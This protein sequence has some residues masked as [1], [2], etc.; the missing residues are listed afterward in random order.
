MPCEKLVEVMELS[1]PPRVCEWCEVVVTDMRFKRLRKVECRG[2]R[3]PGELGGGRGGASRAMG[4]SVIV[5]VTSRLGP[6]GWSTTSKYAGASPR[7]SGDEVFSCAS[8]FAA[9]PELRL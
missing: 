5:I 7:G 1:E 9:V 2:G 6:S 3:C 4:D 8:V